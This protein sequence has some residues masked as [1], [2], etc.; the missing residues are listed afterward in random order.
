MVL[1]NLAVDYSLFDRS[2]CE[3]VFTLAVIVLLS[4]RSLLGDHAAAAAADAE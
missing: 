3:I 4:G 2:T 1:L